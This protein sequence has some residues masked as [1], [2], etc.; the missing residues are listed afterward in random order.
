MP[1]P[2]HKERRPPLGSSGAPSPNLLVYAA[3]HSLTAA[4]YLLTAHLQARC[5]LLLEVAQ[6]R[7]EACG[8]ELARTGALEAELGKC[9]AALHG[10]RKTLLPR[11][12]DP[13]C[14][15]CGVRHK[16]IEIHTCKFWQEWASAASVTG[17]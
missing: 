8:R 14:S 2:P 4:G 16:D 15:V 3:G 10:L 9:G 6:R 5:K 17:E 11:S 1:P 13:R 7:L 12:W